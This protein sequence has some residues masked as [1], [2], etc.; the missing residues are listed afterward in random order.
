MFNDAGGLTC[1]Q[2][3]PFVPA[4]WYVLALLEPDA[5]GGI[6]GAEFRIG[7]VPTAAEGWFVVVNLPPGAD[8]TGDPLAEGVQ[9]IRVCPCR[10]DC[11]PRPCPPL[12]IEGAAWSMVK[13]LFR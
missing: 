13:Q 1:P 10:F 7:G 9:R 2:A 6:T 3:Q 8:G 11:L 4:T 12:A 5:C